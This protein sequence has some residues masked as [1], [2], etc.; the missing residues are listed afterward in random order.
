MSTTAG[1]ASEGPGTNCG[2]DDGAGT[3]GSAW[4]LDE[5]GTAIGG[6]EGNELEGFRIFVELR[7]SRSEGF[8][9]RFWPV[10]PNRQLQNNS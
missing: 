3:D 1:G 4:S 5:G 6:L 7:F 8:L 10:S 9:W 2:E